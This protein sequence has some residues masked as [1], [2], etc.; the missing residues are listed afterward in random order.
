MMTNDVVMKFRSR[1]LWKH[2]GHDIIGYKEKWAINDIEGQ[3]NIY[4]NWKTAHHTFIPFISLPCVSKDKNLSVRSHHSQSGV[5]ALKLISPLSHILYHHSQTH[6][7]TLNKI[8]YC[9]CDIWIKPKI[10]FSEQKLSSQP[11]DNVVVSV[12]TL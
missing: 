1:T 11:I 9:Q 4:T 10:I 5:I 7:N 2:Y 6:D 12:C 3:G 8:S